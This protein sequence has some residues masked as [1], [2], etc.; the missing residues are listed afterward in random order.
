MS[1]AAQAAI[2]ADYNAVTWNTAIPAL[3]WARTRNNKPNG[4]FQC[5]RSVWCRG[6]KMAKINGSFKLQAWCFG[7][8]KSGGKWLCVDEVL[9]FLLALL[10]LVSS[11]RRWN[12]W[13]EGSPFSSFWSHLW[14]VKCILWFSF[15]LVLFLIPSCASFSSFPCSS[16]FSSST[17]IPHRM[18]Y[19]L[20]KRIW[21]SH[22]WDCLLC[23]T[24]QCIYALLCFPQKF[25]SSKISKCGHNWKCTWRIC[26]VI[27]ANEL[28]RL[29]LSL[30]LSVAPYRVCKTAS[31]WS[32]FIHLHLHG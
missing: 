11:S 14:S 26:D 20:P 4:W 17:F 8:L 32:V 2:S 18:R 13:Y 29:W 5:L 21:E 6:N 22:E 28:K 25:S 10:H 31:V 12:V 19:V 15:F 9:F 3:N 27:S 16:Q 30:N 23:C 1:G 7:F 24:C